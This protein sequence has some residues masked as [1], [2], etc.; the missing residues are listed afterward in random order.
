MPKSKRKTPT[1]NDLDKKYESLKRHHAAKALGGDRLLTLA[2]LLCKLD[3][4]SDSGDGWSARCPAHPDTNNSLS[5]HISWGG[6]FLMKCHRGCE[7]DEIVESARMMPQEMFTTTP[8]IKRAILPPRQPCNIE[9]SPT[10]ADPVWESKQIEL[11]DPIHSHKIQ[12]LA[13][14]LG[15]TFDSLYAIGVGWC[16][17]INCWTFPERNGKREICGIVRRF[18]D[19]T[20]RAFAG[21]HRGLTLPKGFDEAEGTLYICEGASD[22]AAALSDGMRAI[23]RPAAHSGFDDLAVLYANSLTQLWWLRTTMSLAP[24]R[25]QQSGW[26]GS[27]P[28]HPE[29][30]SIQMKVFLNRREHAVVSTAANIEWYEGRRVFA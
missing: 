9:P 23:G 3:N 26:P 19:G 7:F 27:C 24:A 1:P 10:S 15:V 22:V 14:Q 5:V 18:N 16:M 2:E 30:K 29:P 13:E 25:K 11:C 20:K 4:V 17:S 8:S 12:D 6:K 28:T 21:G